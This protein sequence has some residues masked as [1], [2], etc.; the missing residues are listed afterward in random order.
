MLGLLHIGKKAFPAF[1]FVLDGIEHPAS[2]PLSL[3]PCSAADPHLKIRWNFERNRL[4][5]T[6]PR[7]TIAVHN[8]AQCTVCVKSAK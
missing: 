6:F 3:L 7:A 1:D 5:H 8:V 4:E 2:R